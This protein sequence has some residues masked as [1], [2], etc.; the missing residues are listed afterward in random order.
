MACSIPPE[1]LNVL[2]YS[3]K[4]GLSTQQYRGFGVWVL[5]TK[6][7]GTRVCPEYP[8]RV[9]GCEHNDIWVP[10]TEGVWVHTE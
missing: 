5:S 3:T 6:H 8:L 9:C 10:G 1:I 4:K 7:E 2:T